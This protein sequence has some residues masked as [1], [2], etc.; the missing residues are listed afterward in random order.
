MTCLSL[1]LRKKLIHL[2]KKMFQCLGW[3][4]KNFIPGNF[5]WSVIAETWDTSCFKKGFLEKQQS[6]PNTC[7]SSHSEV[8]L[9]KGV[10]KIC[11]N[12]TGEH[13]C[14][15]MIS[16]KLQSN[17]IDISLRHG[18]SPVNLLHIFRTLS[19]N[20]SGW[21]LLAFSLLKVMNW[22]FDPFESASFS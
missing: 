14:R 6:V 20:T 5:S 18:C 22:P 10:L 15:N 3:M 4:R 12:F 1:A 19:K 8:F 13:P 16:I 17:F 7:R 21:M 11:S 9:R 2:P